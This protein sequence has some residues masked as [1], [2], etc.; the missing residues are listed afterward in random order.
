MAKIKTEDEK[1]VER[2]LNKIRKNLFEM[3]AWKAEIDVIKAKENLYRNVNYD[4]TGA[5]SSVITLDDILARN[6]TKKNNLQSDIDYT[7]IKISEYKAAMNI[8]N[9]DEKEIICKRY[10][11][12]TEKSISY[13][14]LAKDL[15]CSKMTAMRWHD[16]AI[17]KISEYKCK[18]VEKTK[19]IQICYEDDTNMLRTCYA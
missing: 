5:S 16:A 6:E 17:K 11:V 10:F 3:D 9:N 14:N 7:E 1:K 19:M 12:A 8:L 15:C 18:Q 13:E 2:D 4:I